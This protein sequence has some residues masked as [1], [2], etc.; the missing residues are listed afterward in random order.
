MLEIIKK[1]QEHL[2]LTDS[3]IAKILLHS[4]RVGKIELLKS[5]NCSK[6]DQK[7]YFLLF[8]LLYWLIYI[9]H[10]SEDPIL[11]DS[12]I[13]TLELLKTQNDLKLQDALE[14]NKV[15]TEAY[16]LE[17]EKK[18]FQTILSFFQEYQEEQIL[19]I[20]SLSKLDEVTYEIWNKLE[21]DPLFKE[22]IFKRNKMIDDYKEKIKLLS[23]PQSQD[24]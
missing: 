11:H 10:F 22:M 24:P 9:K 16:F 5:L 2:N 18:E 1:L 13:I 8:H 4:H 3:Q 20:K 12:L 15:Q 21:D 23:N 7:I 6:E 14:E 17:Q 19:K